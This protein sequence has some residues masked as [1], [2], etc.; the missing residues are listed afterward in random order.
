MKKLP[1][2]IDTKKKYKDQEVINGLLAN[3]INEIIDFISGLQESVVELVHLLEKC[4]LKS[5]AK[6]K[7][8][9]CC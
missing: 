3:K 6:K 8:K 4:D 2:K 7:N 9:C 5:E 1:K